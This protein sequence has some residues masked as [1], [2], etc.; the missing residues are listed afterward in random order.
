MFVQK[1]KK[2]VVVD[3][4]DSLG[5]VSGEGKDSSSISI[6]RPYFGVRSSLTYSAY[7]PDEDLVQK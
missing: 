7:S 4:V 2:M 3:Y 5:V 6:S 1:T